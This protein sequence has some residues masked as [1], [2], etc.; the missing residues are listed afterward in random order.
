MIYYRI[1]SG[2]KFL[3]ITALTFSVM[4]YY[5]IERCYHVTH[6]TQMIYYRI[7]SFYDV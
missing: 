5:R 2:I 4:I 1:E 7:E 6:V 3:S